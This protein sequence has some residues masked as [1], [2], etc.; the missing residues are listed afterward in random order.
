[1]IVRLTL[2]PRLCGYGRRRTVARPSSR[3]HWR[4]GRRIPSSTGNRIRRVWCR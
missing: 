1:M 3:I 4:S 2:G